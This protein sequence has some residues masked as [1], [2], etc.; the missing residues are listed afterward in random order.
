MT[1][2]NPVA[3]PTV[4][5]NETAPVEETMPVEEQE[6]VTPPKKK[7]KKKLIIGITAAVTALAVGIGAVAFY[8]VRNPKVY[9]R[10]KVTLYDE[11]GDW[12]RTVEYQYN[13]Q[14]SPTE[15]KRS[16]PELDQVEQVVEVDGFEMIVYE[17]VP[18]G[19]KWIETLTYEYNDQGHCIYAGQI[20]ETYDADGNRTER[21]ERDRGGCEY[22]YNDDGTIDEVPVYSFET[23]SKLS[24]DSDIT[25][26]YHYD[27]DGRLFEITQHHDTSLNNGQWESVDLDF[28]YDSKDRLT[29]SC[30]RYLEAARLYEYEYD[31]KGNL[32][33][34]SLSTA[35]YQAPIDD[36]HTVEE[37]Y[38]KVD[39]NLYCEA[40]F[41]YDSKGRLIGREVFDGDGNTETKVELEY[42]GKFISRMEYED[43]EVQITD[44]EDEADSIAEKLDDND[45]V[46][47]RDKHGNI[48]KAIKADGSYAEFE[49]EAVRLKKGLAQQHEAVMYSVRRIDVMGRMSYVQTFS[50]ASG[51]LS[52]VSYPT[53]ELYDL[54]IAK[55][56]AFGEIH[57]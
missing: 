14:G 34:V 46:M 23:G 37:M 39:F 33:R 15:I 26:R 2:E 30:V 11:N 19:G 16:G 27:D 51:F 48:I 12:Y 4:P 56:L 54:E 17:M 32:E 18:N 47:V 7:S 55:K 29:S 25:M 42:D 43:Y 5:V 52:T 8:L 22:E 20:D 1:Q 9:L 44:D 35:P 36:R 57:Y 53:N 38:P 6:E 50:A 13:D 41:E 40:E 28:R 24:D 10:T 3:E 31:E 49:Y 45:V 21:T